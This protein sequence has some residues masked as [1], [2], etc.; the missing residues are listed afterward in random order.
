MINIFGPINNLGTGIHV[1]NMCNALDRLG[2][3]VC[4]IPP[5]GRVTK[6]DAFVQKWLS[7]QINFSKH[8]PGLMIFD[9][10]F[11]GQ[12]VGTPR[13]GFAVFETNKIDL[14]RLRFLSSCDVV[15]TPS[16]WAQGVLKTHGIESFVVNEGYDETFYEVQRTPQS[17]SFKFLHIGKFEERKGTKQILKCF[18]QVSNDSPI[19]LLMHIDNPFLQDVGDLFHYLRSLGF[20]KATQDSW[21][22]SNKN[23]EIIF[24][25]EMQDLTDLY[26][27]ADVGV[28]PSKGEGWGLPILECIVSGVPVIAGN[29]SGQSEF[30]DGMP[31][32]LRLQEVNSEIANDGVWFHGNSGSWYAT[33]DQELLLRMDHAYFQ[34]RKFRDSISWKEYVAKVREKFTWA[35]AAKGL[36]ELLK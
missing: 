27:M 4:L 34:G 5:Y 22:M 13:I 19:T 28:F 24:T 14:I 17:Q 35:N 21:V 26:S 1:Y 10:G 29:W 16:H 25:H 20:T 3:D 11:M 33:T 15:V 6:T 9:M 7:N 18:S 2:Q 36:L 8:N 31:D 30:L 32:N 23:K 12:F